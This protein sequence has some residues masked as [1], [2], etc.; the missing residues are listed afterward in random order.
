[1]KKIALCISGQPRYIESGYKMF[2]KNLSHFNDMDIF[3]HVWINSKEGNNENLSKLDHI[4]DIFNTYNVTCSL[5]ESQRYDIAPKEC[6]HEEFI[7]WSMFYSIYK[8]NE[9]FSFNKSSYCFSQLVKIISNAIIF[10][11][12]YRFMR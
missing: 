12:T 5:V 9:V 10:F 6:S 3:V 7:H 11:I 2:R 4:K 8:S 1:M